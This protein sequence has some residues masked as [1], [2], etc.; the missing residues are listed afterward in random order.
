MLKIIRLAA[1]LMLISFYGN[2]LAIETKTIP[3]EQQQPYGQ[4][5]QPYGQQQQPYGQQQ[6]PYGQQQ[7]P[8]EGLMKEGIPGRPIMQ[9][10]SLEEVSQFERFIAGQSEKVIS[11]YLRQF[12]YD[13]FDRPLSTFAPS[14]KVPVGPDY[15]FGP[16]DEIKISVWGSFDWQGYVTVSRD[17]NITLPKIGIIG[18]TGLSFKEVKDVL[19]RE[20]AKYY[21]G[22][23][24]NVSMGTLR[25]MNIYVIGNVR[26]P[27]V[28]NVSSLSTLVNALFA[29]GGPGKIGTMRDIQV[30]RSGK[31]IINFDMY[32]L[33][34]KGDKTKDVR[35]MPEDVVFIPAIGSLIGIAGNVKN[36]A[37]Y[38]LRGETRLLDLIEMAGGLTGNAFK[39]RVQVQRIFDHQSIKLFEGDLVDINKDEKKNFTITNGDLVKVFSVAEDI[40][41]VSIEGAVQKMGIFGVNPGITRIMDVI[42]QA[43]GLVYYA[44]D[45]AEIT[46]VKVTQAGP[47]TERLYVDLLKAMEGD[48]IN[49]IPL[50]INDYIFIRAVPEWNLYKTVNIYGEVKYPGKYTITK[51]ESLSSLIERAGGYTDAAYLQ[52]SKVTRESVRKSQQEG[53]DAMAVRLQREILSSSSAQITT[54]SSSE[55]AQSKKAELESKQKFIEFVKELKATGRLTVRLTNLRLLKGTD[56]DIRMEDGD[57][58]TIPSRPGA[59][60]VEGSV[61]SKGSYV[62]SNKYDYRNYIEMSGGYSSYA[63]EDKVYVLKADGSAMMLSRGWTSWNP[64]KSR[65]EL[66]AF[67]RDRK[68]VEPGDTIVVP[69]KLE[70]I[71]WMREIK[72]ITAILMQ[73]AVTAGVVLQLY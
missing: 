21:T 15:I 23:E 29:A 8:Y 42:A 53:L 33:L 72:D 24:M 36:P 55:E 34:L 43:G 14:D 26:T 68:D 39:G 6:Q 58:I 51:D 27:G 73:M 35:L 20:F 49:N 13:L 1:I 22:F 31:T 61:I 30:K 71:A 12:G 10:P 32:D 52:G 66:E 16:G 37:I 18:I 38:E 65:W 19:H 54:A 25:T 60:N 7:Q 4:Q 63:D 3:N 2:V 46:R 48:Q 28:Y 17:G 64:F 67:G 59:I 70:R 47:R 9:R 57:N 56:N 41:T 62:Y 40:S 44:S 50:E 5:Q 11:T 69:E 45:K